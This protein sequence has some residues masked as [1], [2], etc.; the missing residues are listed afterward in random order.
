MPHS[1]RAHAAAFA[2]GSVGNVGPGLDI[3]GLAVA[4]AGDEVVLTR[5]DGGGLVVDDPGHPD[6]PADPTLNTA[7]IAAQAVFRLAG[8]TANVGVRVVKGLPL[9]GGQGGSAASAVA[10]A[11]A[12]NRLID[13]GLDTAA[14]LRCA[15]DAESRVAGRH[16]DNVA[17]S[18]LG[19]LVL[20][21][22]LDP[23]EVIQIPLPATLRIV[24]A[25][26]DQRLQTRAARAVL[27][28]EVSRATALQQAANVAAMVAAA[29]LGDLVLL[30][31]ALDDRIAEPARAALLPGFLAAK[32]A[33]S[34]AGALACSI[35]GAGPTA[36]ALVDGEEVGA[37]VASAMIAA[38]AEAGVEATARIAMVDIEGARTW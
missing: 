3:L 10:G 35:S 32:A 14:L 25:H 18:L 8:V 37:L 26:P 12:A 20:V 27:P 1:P 30:G 15:L 28:A 34:A 4:G 22:S 17:P 11:C 21:R 31:R 38:Y 16:A 7:A 19:G 6:L 5:R 13:A 29:F 36:F 2:P 23:I 33:A 24:L 9:S